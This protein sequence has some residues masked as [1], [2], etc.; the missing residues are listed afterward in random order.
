MKEKV[1]GFAV[2]TVI[3]LVLGFVFLVLPQMIFGIRG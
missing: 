1:V 3:L 2:G